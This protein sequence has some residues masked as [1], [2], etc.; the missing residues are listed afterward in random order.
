MRLETVEVLTHDRDLARRHVIFLN[1][2]R[3]HLK[4]KNELSAEEQLCLTGIESCL[5]DCML[6]LASLEPQVAKAISELEQKIRQIENVFFSSLLFERYILLKPMKQ[7]AQE[8]NLKLNT[9]YAIHAKARDAYNLLQ[10]ITPY[11]DSRGKKKGTP[12]LG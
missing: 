8:L 10:G 2:E 4:A 12:Y 11:K 5:E 7:I 6:Y 3:D 9:A 1:T